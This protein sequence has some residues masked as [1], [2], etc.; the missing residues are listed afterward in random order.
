M[1]VGRGKE[2]YV[3]V[4]TCAA[5]HH[6]RHFFLTISYSPIYIIGSTLGVGAMGPH[7]A[8]GKAMGHRRPGGGRH[9]SIAFPGA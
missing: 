5:M 2:E 4:A 3:A 7:Q 6:A 1:K 9:C 8:R